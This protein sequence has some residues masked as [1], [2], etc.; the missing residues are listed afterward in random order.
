MRATK[1][2]REETLLIMVQ[3]YWLMKDVARQEA[4][5]AVQF[6]MDSWGLRYDPLTVEIDDVI[7][8]DI[9]DHPT[10]SWCGTAACA[11]GFLCFSG[12]IPKGEPVQVETYWDSNIKKVSLKY[13]EELYEPGDIFTLLDISEESWDDITR[14]IRQEDGTLTSA[15]QTAKKIR[16]VIRRD[17]DFDPKHSPRPLAR[18]WAGR[19]KAFEDT[20]VMKQSP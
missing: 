4:F 14:N 18:P 1:F 20:I 8:E 13:N 15:K 16:E 9:K 17:F 10:Q 11:A 12:I 19:Q 3:W 5:R 2:D 6:H 7:G